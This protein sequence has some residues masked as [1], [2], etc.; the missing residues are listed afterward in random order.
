MRRIFLS[1]QAGVALRQLPPGLFH[2]LSTRVR[3]LA[4]DPEP[5]DADCREGSPFRRVD[6]GDQRIVYRAD[7]KVLKVVFVGKRDDGE[8]RPD[9]D[10]K[11]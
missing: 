1:R 5:A 2:T 7:A 4:E 8:D 3:G 6:C 9:L 11:W 10:D